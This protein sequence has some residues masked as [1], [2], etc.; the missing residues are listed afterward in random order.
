VE[1]LEL[2]EGLAE[3]MGLSRNLRPLGAGWVPQQVNGHLERQE[4]GSQRG[5]ADRGKECQ[6]TRREQWALTSPSP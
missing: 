2:Q 5:R 4:Q 6:G 1:K 3:E